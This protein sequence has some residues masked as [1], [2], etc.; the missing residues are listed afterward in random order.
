MKWPKKGSEINKPLGKPRRERES[1]IMIDSKEQRIGG[2]R[3][4]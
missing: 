1:N 4:N 2:R 3:M